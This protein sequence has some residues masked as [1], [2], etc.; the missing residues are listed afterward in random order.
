[1][2]SLPRKPS[3]STLQAPTLSPRDVSPRTRVGYTSSFDGVLNS[4]ESWITRRR[5]AEAPTKTG[6]GS[7]HETTD[8]QQSKASGILEEEKEDEQRGGSG[9]QQGESQSFF[10]SPQLHT[11][12]PHQFDAMNAPTDNL[13]NVIPTNPFPANGTTNSNRYGNDHMG[14]G[15]PPGLVD[16]AAVE[17]SYKDPTGQIQGIYLILCVIHR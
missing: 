12:E 4:G 7:G 5:T 1:M 9:P 14:V 10:P 3:L 17:W 15:P 13:G 6:N 8:N 11:E 2:L 16:S